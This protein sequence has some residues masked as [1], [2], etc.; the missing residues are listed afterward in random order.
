MPTYQ[1]I[2][3]DKI[4]E[5]IREGLTFL[6]E[7]KIGPVTTKTI[8]EWNS[9]AWLAEIESAA[10]NKSLVAAIKSTQANIFSVAST[11]YLHTMHLLIGVVA[12]S[13]RKPPLA[14]MA[15]TADAEYA[16]LPNDHAVCLCF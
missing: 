4:L 7:R 14:G 10:T 9:L 1:G 16:L 6:Q 8:T 11:T 2:E 13:N 3:Q 12:T 5:S 15:C